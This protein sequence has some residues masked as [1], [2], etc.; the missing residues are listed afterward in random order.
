MGAKVYRHPWLGYSYR[1]EN[2]TPDVK[3]KISLAGLDESEVSGIE[4]ALRGEPNE[5]SALTR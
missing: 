1:R 4:A 2:G 5:S 3:R